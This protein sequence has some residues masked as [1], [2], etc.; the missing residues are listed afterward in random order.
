ML[1]QT[2]RHTVHLITHPLAAD[3]KDEA[4]M[5]GVRAHA[6]LCA[7]VFGDLDR[8]AITIADA[9]RM[10]TAEAGDGSH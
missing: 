3:E 1:K 8:G 7:Y 5:R 9:R 2:D 6:A 4:F 10:M